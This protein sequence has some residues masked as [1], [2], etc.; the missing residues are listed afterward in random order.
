MPGP[1]C[2]IQGRPVYIDD[3]ALEKTEEPVKR[4]I[5]TRS[6]SESYHR[7]IQKKWIKRWGYVMKPAMFFMQGAIVMHPAIWREVSEIL[8]TRDLRYT[9]N[10]V[11]GK[12]GLL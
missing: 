5:K 1:V 11:T 2:Q 9:I 8:P 12:E 10:P 4:H 3:R 7:R 6:M